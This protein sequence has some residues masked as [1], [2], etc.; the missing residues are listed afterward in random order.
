MATRLKNLDRDTP[1]LLPPDLREW[2][3]D[4]HIVHFLVD[5]VDR[6]PSVYFSMNRRGTG[7][8]QYPPRMMLTLLI[9]CYA[10]GRFSSRVIEEA[11][12]SD[13]VV[14][15][16]CGGNLHPDHD[17]ICTFRRKNRELFEKAFVE[18][19]LMAQEIAGLKKVGTVSIDGTKIKANASKHAAVSYHRAGEQIELLRK[20]VGQ[21]ASKAEQIDK[22]PLDDGLSIP[23]EI[24]RRE[25]RIKSLE[26]ARS[27]IEERYEH[28]RVRKQVEY[29]RK[30][31]AH[32]ENEKNRRPRGPRP[33]VP[34]PKNPPD[35]K[36]YNFTDP[37]SRIMKTAGNNFEQAYN[38]QA[39]V[40]TETMLIV[41]QYITDAPTDKQ[42][43]VPAV[44][45]IPSEAVQPENILA[46]TGYYGDDFICEVE[47]KTGAVVYCAQAKA[48][49]RLT[50]QDLEKHTQPEAPSSTA[51]MKQQMAHRLKTP[52]GKALY[53]LRKQT[54][55]PA[56]GIIKEVLGFRRFS[57]RG[58]EKAELE[59]SLVCLSYNLKKMYNLMQGC[60]STGSI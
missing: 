14:R 36:Q 5:A 11:T 32:E 54:V 46:D 26:H 57:M 44:E 47:R 43:L 21:L 59:W 27:I 20:E 8:E 1:M 13:V 15:Y 45:K 30:K 56:F 39:A 29:E 4:N 52:E 3:P 28:E 41:G 6:L 55:E 19:L 24:T 10:T 38:A 23:E 58:K 37:E 12:H 42:Q 53:K 35:N 31:A 25:E 40:D 2:I 50:V 33:P 51:P 9:Y 17:T 60:A 22:V 16:I 18:V 34:P 7:D 48:G 49:H